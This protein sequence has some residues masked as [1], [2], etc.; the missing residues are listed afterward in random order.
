MKDAVEFELQEIHR[1]W[2]GYY[3]PRCFAS[4]PSLLL[5]LQ[6]AFPGE[7]LSRIFSLA[8][9]GN[10]LVAIVS[11]VAAYYIKEAWGMVAPFDASLTLLIIGSLAIFLTWPENYGDSNID[12]VT[13][14]KNGWK[15]LMSG[16]ST[17]DLLFQRVNT[18]R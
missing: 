14:F 10:G 3:G 4:I 16:T 15:A 17:K 6:N 18:M 1:Q 11:G 9:L 5:N 2:R 7:L 12:V 13:S 8:V